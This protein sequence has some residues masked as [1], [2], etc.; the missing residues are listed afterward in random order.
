MKKILKFT[1]LSALLLMLA[2]TFTSCEQGPY[3]VP[4]EGS[5]RLAGVLYHNPFE[6][7]WSFVELAPKDCD[8]C[9]TLTFVEVGDGRV[10]LEGKSILNTVRI[11]ETWSSPH[12][13]ISIEVI[14]GDKDEP[15]DGNRYIDYLRRISGFGIDPSTLLPIDERGQRR[16]TL[17]I[18]ENNIGVITLFFN[19]I[20]NIEKPHYQF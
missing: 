2:K 12:N 1:A 17:F 5:W 3:F 13:R 7:E 6:Q 4:H 15:Y 16:L 14:I 10:V 18:D 20:E 19:R 9:F 11:V 8:T